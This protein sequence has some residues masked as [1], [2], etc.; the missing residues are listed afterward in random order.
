MYVERPM[1]V[2]HEQIRAL[3]STYRSCAK[4]VF[5]G[6]NRRFSR[7]GCHIRSRL[8]APDGPLILGYLVSGH[9][10]SL[11]RWYRRPERGTRLWQ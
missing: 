6:Y 8:P 10:R 2:S 4:N 7:A 9:R 11:N 1:A 3:C 5:S